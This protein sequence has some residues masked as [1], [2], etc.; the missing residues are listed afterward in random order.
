METEKNEVVDLDEAQAEQALQG[1]DPA[2]PYEASGTDMPEWATIPVG[3]KMPK[4][5]RSVAFL[6]IRADWTDEP[7]KGDR[8]C[9]CWSLTEADERLA[10]ARSRGDAQRSL[11][12][13]AKQAIRVVDGHRADWSGKMN[14]PGAVNV[15]WNEIG[16]KGR[17]LVRNY[18][19]QTHSL[20]NEEQIDFFANHF[21]N[22]TVA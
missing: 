15:F 17:M 13:L 10:Y 5:G 14:A 3:M 20:T 19:L 7:D 12:E 11:G 2:N 16:A 18:Y 6:R 9:M 22:V 4:K 21:V 1:D 8:W